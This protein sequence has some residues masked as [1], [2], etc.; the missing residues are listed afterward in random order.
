[1]N[2]EQL[3]KYLKVIQD[4]IKTLPLDV[5]LQFT[6]STVDPKIRKKA[7]Y[8]ANFV[9]GGGYFAK[10]LENIGVDKY[11]T[12]QLLGFEVEGK[13][14]EGLNIVVGILEKEK[15][16]AQRLKKIDNKFYQIIV[17]MYIGLGI[18]V[19]WWLPLLTQKLILQIGSDERIKKDFLFSFLANNFKEVNYLLWGSIYGLLGFALFLLFYVYKVHRFIMRLLPATRELEKV[20]DKIT[21]LT[22]FEVNQTETDAIRQMRRIFGNKWNL[23]KVAQVFITRPYDFSKTDLFTQEEKSLLLSMGKLGGDKGVI[24]FLIRENE[25]KRDYLIDKI[26]AFMDYF[27]LFAGATVVI[28]MWSFP[29]LV[30][31][32]ITSLM[33]G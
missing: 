2:N 24:R 17:L 4:S 29:M 1:M 33:R 18:F 10:A 15:E 9:K 14:E 5:V 12:R 28:G 7:E 16:K 31:M 27:R 21:L 3:V 30:I 23:D 19:L 20:N 25:V 22:I 13:L 6:V 8:I 11:I 26:D 32:K